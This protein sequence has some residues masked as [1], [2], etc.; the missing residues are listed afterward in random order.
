M[1]FTDLQEAIFRDARLNVSSERM[2]ST[3]QEVKDALNENLRRI[4]NKVRVPHWLLRSSSLSLTSGTSTYSLEWF[5]RQALA[6]YTVDTYAHKVDMVSLAN[7]N[8][9]GLRASNSLPVSGGPWMA[10]WYPET[11]T[12]TYTWSAATIAYNSATMTKA[13][14]TDFVAA[15]VGQA[16]RVNGEPGDFLVS[17]VEGTTSLTL[18]R[19][20]IGRLSGN[21]KGSTPGGLAAG[22]AEIGPPGRKRVE[23]I[24]AVN[25]TQ[26]IY[27]HYIKQPQW[28]VSGA[29]TPEL[30]EEFHRLLLLMAKADVRIFRENANGYSM[31]QNEIREAMQDVDALNAPVLGTSHTVPYEAIF[32]CTSYKKNT[33]LPGTYTR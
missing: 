23:F 15:M 7:A 25:A 5:V 17:S 20:Y 28:M 11:T 27:Y 30:P 18:N 13:A 29:D 32:P 1:N 2:D 8:A 33:W 21:A 14:G 22:R 6:F 24:P 26:T 31:L 16:V 12:S 10:T 9:S 19:A 3:V 4:C